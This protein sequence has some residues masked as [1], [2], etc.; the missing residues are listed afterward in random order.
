[1]YMH[2]TSYYFVLYHDVVVVGLNIFYLQQNIEKD[3]AE[4]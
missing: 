3:R 1:M 2:M 4:Q